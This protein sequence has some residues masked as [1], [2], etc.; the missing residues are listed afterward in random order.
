MKYSILITCLIF[1]LSPVSAQ[2]NKA[3]FLHHSTGS[4][5]YSTGKVS[6]WITNYNTQNKTN[7][8]VTEFS[9]PDTPWDWENY[10]YDYWK[11]WVNGS[12]NNTIE[13]IQCLDNLCQKY[14][15]IIFKHCYPG[16]GIEKDIDNGNVTSSKK[17][18]N[19]YKLQYRAL[20]NLFDQYPNNKFMVWTLVPLH[21]NATTSEVAKRAAEFVNWVKTEWLT[22]NGKSHPNVSVFDF[23][24][25]AAE[26]NANPTQ[27]VQYCLKYEYEGDHNGSNSHPNT[28]ANQTIG[29][30]FA[31][32][33]VKV[34]SK[35]ATN[36]SE[37]TDA[38]VIQLQSNPTAKTIQ[39]QINS[40]HSTPYFK[41]EIFSILGELVYSDAKA[42]SSGNIKLE[43]NSGIYIFRVKINEKLISYKVM[44]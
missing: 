24:G 18:I 2:I 30:L 29:P 41:I 33:I 21:R 1:F 43:R 40:N 35:N 3:I 8:S 20:L 6:Q 10:P 28:I 36:V 17:T 19:N 13:N 15:L 37:R 5:V 7:Y 11:L 27:G 26:Q 12:C 34:L 16:A 14:E 44:I 4:G 25:H 23:F 38:P 31:A 22:E 9:Y 32:E 39:Y 42:A